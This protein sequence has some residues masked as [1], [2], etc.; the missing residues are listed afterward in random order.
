MGYYLDEN[1]FL[2]QD[3]IQRINSTDLTPSIEPTKEN[4]SILSKAFEKFGI[5]SLADL[6]KMLKDKNKYSEYASMFSVDENYFVLLRREIEGWIVDKIKLSEIDWIDEK[7]INKL[8]SLNI[9]NTEEAYSVY[10]DKS[11]RKEILDNFQNDQMIIEYIFHFSEIMR[12]RWVSKNVARV[13]LELGYDTVT[14]IKTAKAEKLAIEIDELNAK[15]KYY[16]GKIGFRDIS[17][18]IHEASYVK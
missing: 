11:Q 8:S 14:K 2:L 13:L 18:L 5:Q 6:R 1:R 9:V 3:I 10:M 12:I 15:K 7:I 4:I 16:K 17:R